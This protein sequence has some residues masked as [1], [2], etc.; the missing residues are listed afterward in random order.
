MPTSQEKFDATV[1]MV[2]TFAPKFGWKW[3]SDSKM[4]RA[5][6]WVFD[7]LGMPGYLLSF[8][9]TFRN[10]VGRPSCAKSGLDYEWSVM[11]HEGRHAYDAQRMTF[12]LFA[13]IYG[14]PQWLG[15]L[16]VPLAI[17]LVCLTASW[18]G[19]LGL[20]ALGFLA[21]IPAIGRT[22]LELRGYRVSMSC[23]YFTYSG[24]T[25]FTYEVKSFAEIFEGGSYYYMGAFLLSGYVEDKLNYY[26]AELNAGRGYQG[27]PYLTAVRELALSFLQ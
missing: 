26:L 2:K 19:L 9:T 5:I 11:A 21:P 15:L 20:L 13:L 4:H 6:G 12:P 27:D 25:D 7:K 18:L 16:A 14:F 22:I 8:W 23:D 24:Q 3:K 10:T 1:N 17:L